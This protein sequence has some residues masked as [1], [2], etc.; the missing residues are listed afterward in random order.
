MCAVGQSKSQGQAGLTGQRNS[1]YLVWEEQLWHKEFW[2]QG[3]SIE[4]IFAN[5]VSQIVTAIIILMG[6]Q[7]AA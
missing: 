1:P 3:G 6:S 2:V 5:C 7:R 4:A